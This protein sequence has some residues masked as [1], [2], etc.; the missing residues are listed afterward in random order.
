VPSPGKI[1]AAQDGK[2]RLVSFARRGPTYAQNV[3]HQAPQQ[4]RGSASLHSASLNLIVGPANSGRAEAVLSRFRAALDRDPVL[5]VPTA[6]DVAGFERQLSAGGIATLGGSIATFRGL[7]MQVT[8]A[9]APAVP[10]ELSVAQRQALIRAAIA[11]VAPRLLRRSAARPGFAPA[12]DSLIA[13]L[14]AALVSP[15]EFATVVA[16][17]DDP[18]YETEL[19]AMYR[20]YCELRDASG[21]GDAASTLEAAI[22]ALRADPDAWGARPVLVYA[23]D[24][25]SRAQLE[26]LNGLGT[27]AEVTVA[28]TFSDR[29]ALSATAEL[30]AVLTE[31]LDARLDEPLPFDASYTSSP[32]LR[33]LDLHLFE[34]EADPIEPDDGLVLLKSAGARGEAEAIGI[35]IARLLE[36]GHEPDDVAIVLRHPSSS[37]PVLARVLRELDVPVALEAS[38]PLS[39]TAVGGSLIALCRAATDERATDALL[40]HL[41]LDPALAPNLADTVEARIRRGGASTVTEAVEHFNKPPRHLGRLLEA[42]DAAARLNAL[43]RTARELAEG[44]HREQAPL[45]GDRADPSGAPF[46]ALELRAGVAAAELVIELAGVGALP[47]CDQ[48]DLADAIEALESSSVPIWRG[49][50]SGRVRIMSPYRARAARARVMFIAALQDGDFPSAAPPDPLLSEERRRKIGNRDLR[51]TE[52]AEQERYLFFSCVSRPTERLYLSWQSCDEDGTALARSP[53]IDEVLDLIAPDPDAAEARLLRA[54][55]PERSVPAPDEAT[56]D[57]TLARALAIGGWSVDRPAVL[58]RIGAGDRSSAVE[59]LF[60]GLPDPNALPGPLTSPAVLDQLAAREVFSAGSLE[61]WVTCPYKWFVEHELQPQRLEPEA[62]PLWL[63]SL[64]HDALEALYRDP[65][66]ADSIPRPADLERWRERFAELLD[67]AAT[68]RSGPIN[69]ARR[70]ALQRARAQV[71]AFLAAEAETETEFRPRPDLLE[72]AFGP[73]DDG[74]N[75][76]AHGALALGDVSLRGR[77]DRIDVDPAGRAVVRDYKTGKSVSK[78]GDFTTRGTLQI[79]LYMRAAE[80]VLGLD[81][82][83]GLYH[84]LGAVGAEKRKPRGLVAH[85]AEELKGLGIVGRDRREAEEFEAALDEAERTAVQAAG[86]MR[87][88]GIARRPIGGQCPKYCTFQPICRLERALG[89]VGDE[90]GNGG[91]V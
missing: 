18:G 88:G 48:P 26:L 15:A 28:V 80:R 55:G 59:E 14:Q 4:R 40:A 34:A 39:T 56:T 50:A 74:E 63:G 30:I 27:A 82:V 86:E 83:A 31:E 90:N 11:R 32:T 81:P 13:E 3:S 36:S 8:R 5:V 79:Q 25:L 37:G 21:R 19:A 16:E 69:Y 58:E 12:L 22:S 43:A 70:A 53:F 60:A 42:T 20:A 65:P 41:R 91:D 51:R 38:A 46:S 77:I 49:P 67:R 75:D 2:T 85:E 1:G 73:F 66:G 6:D 17:L 87:S 54:R 33:H 29:R 84:P 62:D 76:D 61:G 57:R 52:A 64:V 9:V 89:A 10:P 78:A 47:G 24:D 7:T 71:D 45:A 44:A 23:F 68:A 35:E 72:V